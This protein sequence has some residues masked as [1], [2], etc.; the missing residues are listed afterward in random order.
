[1]KFLIKMFIIIICALLVGYILYFKKDYLRETGARVERWIVTKIRAISGTGE[2]EKKAGSE[3]EKWI[4]K[5]K[6]E[7]DISEKDRKQLEKIIQE[8][9]N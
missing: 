1:M 3:A 9:E 4:N 6:M 8:H 2:I 5:K 7:E